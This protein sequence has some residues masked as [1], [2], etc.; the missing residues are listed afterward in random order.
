MIFE[1]I[2]RYLNNEA[3]EEEVASIFE[4]IEISEENKEQFIAIKKAWAMTATDESAKRSTWKLIEKEFSKVKE[5][6]RFKIWKYA[7]ILMVLIGLG[8]VT[9][10]LYY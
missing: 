2:Y 6:K 4:W 9:S 10:K 8:K 3:S 7:A 1:L 5:K